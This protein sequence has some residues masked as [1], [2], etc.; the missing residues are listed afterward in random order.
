MQNRNG[1]Y[2][3][4]T[5]FAFLV[6][7][8][9]L[10][11][12]GFAARL[13][14][15]SDQVDV[16]QELE[17]IANVID[18]IQREY[19]RDA[20][21]TKIVEGALIGMMGSL[22]RHSSFISVD[23]LTHMR[24]DT[25]GE[26]EGIGVQIRPGDNGYIEVVTPI[27]GSP[28]ADAG[29]QPFDMIV[30]IDG[31]S[32]EEMTTADAAEQIRGQRGT[33]VQLTILRENDDE[34][35]PVETFDVDVKRDRVALESIKEAGLLEGGVGYIR[36]SDFKETTA[37]D[38][39]EHLIEFMDEG[40]TAFILDLRW[41][42]GGLLSSSQ[43]VCD[44][45]LPKG[46]LVTYTKGRPQADGS[47]NRDDMKLLTQSQPVIPMNLPMAV[48]VNEHSASSSE[49]VTGALQYHQRALIVG[50]KTFGKGSVQTIIPLGQPLNT[51][52]RLTTA[53]YYTPADVTIDQQG[54]LPDVDVPMDD[55][56]L[57][58]LGKQM[59]DSYDDHPMTTDILNHGT[60][61]GYELEEDMVD[62]VQL[63]RAAELLRE[64]PVWENLIKKYHRDVHETQM[65]A[66]KEG[67]E[68]KT[69]APEDLVIEEKDGQKVL[70]I[71][72]NSGET[73][74][75]EVEE[76]TPAE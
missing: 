53:L 14:A 76:V 63:K 6:A 73:S 43:E 25:K 57:R 1:K 10:L 56:T 59:S 37:D 21:V 72:T 20:D 55:E 41:N 42:P 23:D 30:A 47:S 35:E 29:L 13:G 17:P 33:T 75:E 34:K 52:L 28:A 68:S 19:V 11:S 38:I 50:G 5:L 26:F 67:D 64:D 65:A 69:I 40:M 51:A 54:I 32:T 18:K 49:I 71:D 27:G 45:F 62:D 48:L 39:K 7:T 70:R 31:Q 61:S 44:L 36:V 58:A 74:E 15:Q 4:L 22:D 16:Y 24:E 60:I 2:E 12:N 66:T 3:F 9:L 8:G 46:S